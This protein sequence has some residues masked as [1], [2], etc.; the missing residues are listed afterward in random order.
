[1]ITTAESSSLIE[2]F[3]EEGYAVLRGFLDP[4]IPAQV[5]EAVQEVVEDHVRELLAQ[6]TISD[7]FSEES[8]SVRLIKVLAQRWKVGVGSSD[9]MERIP[10][11]FRDHLKKSLL[12]VSAPLRDISSS[13]SRSSCPQ[14]KG[15]VGFTACRSLRSSLG[16]SLNQVMNRAS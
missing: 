3:H 4:P 5:E 10:L 14:G 16:R 13:Y 6:G 2:Q 9:A 1:M 12:R 11:R 15:M 7:P 8:F